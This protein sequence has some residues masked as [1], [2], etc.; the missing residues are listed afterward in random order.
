[1]LLLLL[2]LLSLLLLICFISFNSVSFG[3][4]PCAWYFEDGGEVKGLFFIISLLFERTGAP[5]MK[6]LSLSL[7]L[8]GLVL[9]PL[10]LEVGVG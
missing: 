10:A 7:L 4:C 8:L 9:V 3:S 5:I 1:M 6:K 2:L